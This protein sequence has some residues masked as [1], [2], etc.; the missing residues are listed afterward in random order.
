[1]TRRVVI[2][3]MGTVN[4][5]AL[6]LKSFWHGLCAGKS[7]VSMIEQFDTSAFKVRIGGEVKNWTAEPKIDAKSARRLDRFAQFALVAAID[8][9]K[10]CGLDFSKEDPFRCGT[11][12]GSGIGGLNE[13]ED[14]HG[15][16]LK[17]GPSKINPFVI[18]KMIANSG[19]GNISI[20]FGLRGPNT[21]ISTA[22]ASAAH[23]VGD[24]LRAIQYDHADVMVTG[25]SEAAITPMGLGGFC[26][27]RALS[28]RNDNPQAASRPFDKDR[29]GFILSEGAGVLVLE[30]LDHAR[31][32]GANIYA[33]VL[34]VGSTADAHHITAPHPDGL[35]AARAMINALKDAR[36]NVEDID[37]INA[38]GTS[39]EL[40]DAAETGA[41]KRVFG[42][43][44]RK[45]A[46]S[47]TKSMIGHLLGAS[48]G[49]E[50]IA[51]AMSIKTGVIH[52]TINYQT[53]D[54]ACDLDY[55]PNQARETRVRRA[56][57]NSFG[58]GGHNCCVAVGAVG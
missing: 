2:T 39:T 40:G 5:L 28:T 7:G 43:H 44:A 26:S 56:L 13:F 32:R 11:I 35:G 49:V 25:G 16:Y 47:S 21:A 48:G 45:L 14:Q 46:I 51:C 36:A 3:G 34:G 27:A 19:A 54:P 42:N 9:V 57:S 8:A 37:Y 22:C 24:A 17:D 50:L 53:P 38:H 1:M 52:P 29:D 12:M 18:P 15:R 58:F 6:D 20:Q 4:S 55:V 10:D 23:A 30:E 33:E 31:R 41:I